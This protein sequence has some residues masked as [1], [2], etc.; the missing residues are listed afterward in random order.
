M[1]EEAAREL[2]GDRVADLRHDVLVRSMERMS[3][4]E[5]H[6]SHGLLMRHFSELGLCSGVVGVF[7]IRHSII[8]QKRAARW[9]V[10]CREDAV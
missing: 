3:D 5:R 1:K 2:G 10:E 7:S 8:Y 6:Q 4:V 9:V